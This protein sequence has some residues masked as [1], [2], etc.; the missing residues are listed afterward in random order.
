MMQK[1]L[2]NNWELVLIVLVLSILVLYRATAHN[3]FKNDA[4]RWALSSMNHSNTVSV[5]KIA[6]LKEKYLLI[7]LDQANQINIPLNYQSIKP[8]SIFSDKYLN[9]ILKFDGRVILVSSDPGIS[10]RIWMILSQMGRTNLFILTDNEDNEVLKFQ[11]KPDIAT[12]I[13]L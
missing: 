8:D 2:K 13:S 3:H 11:L 7:N 12:G 6:F 5:Q 4:K 9:P 10:A 1:F